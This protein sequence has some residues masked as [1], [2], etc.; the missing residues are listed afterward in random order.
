[1]RFLIFLLILVACNTPG[2]HFRGLPGTKVVVDG[3]TFEVRVRDQLSEAIRTNAQ[4]APRFG[5][6][7]GKA[8]VAME[9]VSGCEVT[10]MRG[11]Q[12]QALGLLDCGQGA[13]E[14]V[15]YLVGRSLTCHEISAYVSDATGERV[16]EYDCTWD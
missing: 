16:A 5:P 2:P 13:P 11:D 6:I 12:A 9:Q 8:K 3:A 1:M 14:P 15:G 10:E 4:Y 7:A